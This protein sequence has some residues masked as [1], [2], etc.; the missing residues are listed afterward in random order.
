[1][2]RDTFKVRYL[3]R[4]LQCIFWKRHKSIAPTTQNDFRYVAQYV[5]VWRS[6]IPAMRNETTTHLIPP[7]MTTSAELPIGTAIRGSYG[8]L[9]TV[10]TTN[11]TSSEHTL[12]PQTPEWNGDPCYAF[13]KMFG[14]RAIIRNLSWAHPRITRP[15]ETR[16]TLPVPGDWNK[17]MIFFRLYNY[18]V[19]KGYYL[20]IFL[21]SQTTSERFLNDIRT[22]IKIT[23]AGNVELGC[24]VAVRVMIAHLWNL[25]VL[26]LL[27]LVDRKEID[28]ENTY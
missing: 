19:F 9:R 3:P 8:R 27:F 11:A 2:T 21:G 25:C 22:L 6:G 4:K 10:S 13:G 17:N 26:R 7:K 20:V 18:C 24:L 12:N 28:G 14:N 1:M 16:R 23:R 5:W 15:L